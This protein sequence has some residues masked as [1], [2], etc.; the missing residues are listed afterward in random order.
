M[1]LDLKEEEEEEEDYYDGEDIKGFV[2]GKLRKI[3]EEE[4]GEYKKMMK[5]FIDLDWGN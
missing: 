2:E 5:E 3:V 4:S 1:V